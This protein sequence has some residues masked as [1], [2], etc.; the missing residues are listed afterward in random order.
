MGDL[1][2]K[3]ASSGSLKIQDQAGTD[4]ITTGTSS[5]LT[6]G[7]GV[8]FP[9]GGT[10]NPISIAIISDQKDASSDGGD[11]NS[12]DWRTRELNREISDPDGIV[13]ISSDQFTLG[14]GTYFLDAQA[15]AY[16]VDAHQLAIY[17]VTAGAYLNY[18]SITQSR[19][20][21]QTVTTAFVSFIHTITANNL[22]EIRHRGATTKS[23]NGFGVSVSWAVG[24][25][26]VVKIF[27]LK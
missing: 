12:G 4:F 20:T 24:H 7:S 9:A 13:S 8:T 21:D 25:F 2:I 23:S 14:A 17:D 10:G 22:Y 16:R 6:L 19:S 1:I 26:C 11:F 27:K 5:G 15:P 3:P 18:G